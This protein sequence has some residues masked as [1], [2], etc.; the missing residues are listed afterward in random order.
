MGASVLRDCV[1]DAVKYV[2]WAIMFVGITVFCGAPLWVAL[3][4]IYDMAKGHP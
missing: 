3:F 2:D 4:I 1:V